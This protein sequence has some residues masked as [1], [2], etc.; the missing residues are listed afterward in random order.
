[1][2]RKSPR[3][4][5]GYWPFVLPVIF[6]II[7]IVVQVALLGYFKQ[8]VPGLEVCVRRGTN[9]EAMWDSQLVQECVLVV[10]LSITV[11]FALLA[12]LAGTAFKQVGLLRSAAKE[13]GID[14]GKRG[15]Q[16]KV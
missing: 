5:W 4:I 15:G 11:T 12:V 8:K 13:L 16:D 3:R 2:I 7:G 14:D 9:V 10:S 6:V 1:M